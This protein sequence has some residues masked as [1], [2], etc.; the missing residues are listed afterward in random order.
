MALVMDMQWEMPVL[1]AQPRELQP[2]AR[3]SALSEGLCSSAG[4]G[5][6]CGALFWDLLVCGNLWGCRNRRSFI[7]IPF[8][9]QLCLHKLN[10]FP[11]ESFL[12]PCEG[13]I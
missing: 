9:C 13:D 3:C 6:V 11:S 1:L 4:V 8:P 10:S 2:A 7:C 12:F 5:K